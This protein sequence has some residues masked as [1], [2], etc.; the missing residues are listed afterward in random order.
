MVPKIGSGVSLVSQTSTPLP[1]F[2]NDR[3]SGAKNRRAKKYEAFGRRPLSITDQLAT[4]QQSFSCQK[5][6][7][8][9]WNFRRRQCSIAHLRASA[10]TSWQ[11]RIH[12]PNDAGTG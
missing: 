12:S 1:F 10:C 3:S 4:G 9:V 8:A 5:S 7:P 6:A 11:L 2:L